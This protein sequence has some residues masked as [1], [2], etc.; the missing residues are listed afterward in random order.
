LDGGGQIGD[1]ATPHGLKGQ[2]STTLPGDE[3]GKKKSV[4]GLGV[5][6]QSTKKRSD[7]SVVKPGKN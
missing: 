1:K 6:L 3:R 2:G 4:P 5:N 7:F